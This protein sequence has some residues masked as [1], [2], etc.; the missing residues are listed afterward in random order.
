M[1]RHSLRS[2]VGEIMHSG[3]DLLVGNQTAS[4]HLDALNATAASM[5]EALEGQSSTSTASGQSGASKPSNQPGF[6]SIDP[7]KLLQLVNM[8]RRF[9]RYSREGNIPSKEQRKYAR[10][11][12]KAVKHLLPPSDPAQSVGYDA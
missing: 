8:T 12:I 2:S 4:E 9:V 5:L 11:S 10:R 3:V 7:S 6:V 1:D